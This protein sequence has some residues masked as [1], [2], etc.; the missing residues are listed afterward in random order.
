[1]MADLTPTQI[2][3]LLSVT[4][5][6]LEGQALA[7]A[8]A[9]VEADPVLAEELRLQEA[10]L[11][12]LGEERHAPMAD[13]EAARMRRAVLDEVLPQPPAR[14]PWFARL[15]PATAVLV[16][17]VAGIGI[18]GNL[19]SSETADLAQDE[20]AAVA[21]AE[22]EEAGRDGAPEAL[23]EAEA[24]AADAAADAPMEAPLEGATSD[25]LAS[26][27]LPGVDL[28]DLGALEAGPLTEQQL[29]V[30]TES[31]DD[32]PTPLFVVTPSCDGVEFEGGM[33]LDVVGA[34]MAFVDGTEVRVVL[35]SDGVVLEVDLSDCTVVTTR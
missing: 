31:L 20:M 14:V 26:A 9:R 16:L 19:G 8:R 17:V 7:E 33:L 21:P 32:V 3:L 18:V 4:D 27:A 25:D 34:A 24:P 12:H 6:S 35:T 13:F 22:S 1:M 23:P 11:A 29:A 5:G 2:D 30:L 15:V 28:P 10:A